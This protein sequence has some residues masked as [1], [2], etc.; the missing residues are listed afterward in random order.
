MGVGKMISVTSFCACMLLSTATLMAQMPGMDAAKSAEKSKVSSTDA[1]KTAA[2]IEAESPAQALDE[3]L[4][5]LEQEMM[6]VVNAMP[7]DKYSFAPAAGTFAASQGAKF[8]GVRS[9]A[10]QV[11][12]V[13][14]ANYSFFSSLSGMKPDVDMKSIGTLTK[15]EDIVA[16]LAK[17][18]AFGHKAIA[19]IT[20]QNAF[21]TIKPVDGMKTRASL[22]AFSVAHGY[23]HYGQMVEYLRM[24]GVV[25]PGSK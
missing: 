9:F 5:L 16:M 12:H 23:D 17:S 2:S 24:N 20:A 8:D 11:T 21:L 15:K 14:Q 3:P 19:T 13:T 6:G 7:A 25:P 10:A 1:G 18:F 4:S 22:A